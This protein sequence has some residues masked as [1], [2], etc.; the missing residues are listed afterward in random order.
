[1]PPMAPILLRNFSV[2]IAPLTERSAT[3]AAV[4][5]QKSAAT[6][7]TTK[8]KIPNTTDLFA[9]SAPNP[10]AESFFGTRFMQNFSY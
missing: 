6:K 5:F 8:G 2:P 7:P 3:L 4:G 10:N 9:A 1:M